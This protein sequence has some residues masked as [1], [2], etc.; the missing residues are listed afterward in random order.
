MANDLRQPDGTSMDEMTAQALADNPPKRGKASGRR[1]VKIDNI[2]DRL[3]AL[4]EKQASVTMVTAFLHSPNKDPVQFIKSLTV[5]ENTGFKIHSDKNYRATL[6]GLWGK[7]VQT[8]PA[9]PTL[10]EHVQA[11]VFIGGMLKHG[12]LPTITRS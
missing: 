1:K 4:F 10:P 8:M 12:N 7:A 5:L 2:V 9:L 3:S 6:L 11:H